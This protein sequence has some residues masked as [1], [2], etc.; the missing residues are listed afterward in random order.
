MQQSRIGLSP[1]GEALASKPGPP[2]SIKE[3]ALN[4]AL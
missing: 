3:S 1:I 2:I 4:I